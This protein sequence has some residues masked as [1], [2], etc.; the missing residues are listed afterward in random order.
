MRDVLVRGAL[1]KGALVSVLMK[2]VLMRSTP[3]V[4]AA[5]VSLLFVGVALA[6]PDGPATNNPTNNPTDNPATNNPADSTMSGGALPF[7][8][9]PEA[10][11]I[12]R[13][14]GVD[15]LPLLVTEPPAEETEADIPAPVIGG[16]DSTFNPFSPLLLPQPEGAAEPAPPSIQSPAQSPTASPAQTRRPT[17]EAAP[18]APVSPAAPA[19]ATV[20]PAPAPAARTGTSTI[21]EAVTA[22]LQPPAARRTLSTG[23]LE[24]TLSTPDTLSTLGPTSGRAAI[25]VP[26]S[27]SPP[28]T[29]PAGTSGTT[30]TAGLVPLGLAGNDGNL[31]SATSNTVSRALRDLRVDFTAMATGT[32]IFRV[33]D[34][35]LPVLVRVGEPLP[36]TELVLSRLTTGS[37]QFTSAD[38]RH[39]LSLNP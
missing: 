31:T 18:T 4:R 9:E 26:P 27:F 3:V 14:V 20:I 16:A 10:P 30:T 7:L 39:T 19:A 36:G 29:A 34:S 1:A 8:P 25:R 28:S 24:S 12:A 21:P 38:V 2:R 15:E 23:L 22:R 11:A 5:L 32:G 17:P 6:A 37:A 13:D 33:G 35:A